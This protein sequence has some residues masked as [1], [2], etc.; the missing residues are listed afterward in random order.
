MAKGAVLSSKNDRRSC[1]EVFAGQGPGL[2][3]NSEPGTR[4]QG[5]CYGLAPRLTTGCMA[6]SR[7]FP[8]LLAL[9]DS[10]IHRRAARPCP[11]SSVAGRPARRSPPVRPLACHAHRGKTFPIG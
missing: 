7:A 3:R 1:T 6:A 5:G 8:F 11:L 4:N 9:E 2:L 10:V